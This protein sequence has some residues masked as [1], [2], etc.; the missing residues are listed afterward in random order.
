MAAHLSLQELG[1]P[2]RLVTQASSRV[3]VVLKTPYVNLNH[4][5]HTD[6]IHMCIHIPVHTPMHKYAHAH[7][8]YTHVK[9]LTGVWPLKMT[10]F[11]FLMDVHTP[12]R[13]CIH[14]NIC[15][16]KH[17]RSLW[18]DSHIYNGLVLSCQ[19]K[20]THPTGSWALG[21]HTATPKLTTEHFASQKLQDTTLNH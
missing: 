21:Y 2:A 13:V 8:I 15:L 11:D 5:M 18:V 4:Y 6:Y 20:W 7:H 14:M 12:V 17:T 19:S 10:R 9:K 3:W 16:H 1:V